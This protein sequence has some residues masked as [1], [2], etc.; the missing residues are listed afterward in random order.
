MHFTAGDD[1]MFAAYCFTCAAAAAAFGGFLAVYRRMRSESDHQRRELAARN[2]ALE[3]AYTELSASAH[4]T[5][6]RD[7]FVT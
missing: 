7:A 4:T 3:T 5:H 2:Q 6:T 1:L